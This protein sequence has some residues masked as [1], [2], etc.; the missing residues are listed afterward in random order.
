MSKCVRVSGRGHSLLSQQRSSHRPGPPITREDGC[1]WCGRWVVVGGAGVVATCEHHNTA[2]RPNIDPGR[3]RGV[4]REKRGGGASP[5]R[6]R[7]TIE[8][9]PPHPYHPPA[10]H[11]H[12]RR[13]PHIKTGWAAR[14]VAATMAPTHE[15][16]P[17]GTLPPRP[18]PPGAALLCSHH[19][20]LCT[21]PPSSSLPTRSCW[22]WW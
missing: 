13:H 2:S 8:A 9:A 7:G 18:V 1:V 19:I 3:G 4:W 17:P 11:R 21:S 22:C 16:H 5:A 20:T 6:P 15:G 14:A 10:A 12:A